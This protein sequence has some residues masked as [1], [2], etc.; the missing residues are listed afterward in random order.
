MINV[1]RIKKN[2]QSDKHGQH[3]RHVQRTGLEGRIQTV[4]SF[5]EE[6]TGRRRIQQAGDRSEPGEHHRGRAAEEEAAAGEGVGG[7]IAAG[8]GVGGKIAA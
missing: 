3:I 4:H 2:F 7:K 6:E 8:E 5:Q 1:I